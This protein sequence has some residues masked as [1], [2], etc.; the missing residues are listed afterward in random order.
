MYFQK[1]TVTNY[2]VKN[3]SNPEQKPWYCQI[4]KRKTALFAI[5]S[6]KNPEQITSISSPC[7]TRQQVEIIMTSRLIAP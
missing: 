6:N 3:C 4:V 5:F 2:Q 7:K 1:T